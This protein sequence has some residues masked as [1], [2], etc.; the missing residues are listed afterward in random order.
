MKLV[1]DSNV[2]FSFFSKASTT[3]ELIFMLETFNLYTPSFCIEELIRYR[4][5]ICKKSG[6]SADGFEEA[7]EE[8]KLFVNVVSLSEYSEFLSGVGKISPD[9]DD[10]DLFALALKLDCPIWSNET[11]L[12]KQS[13]VK[14]LSTKEIIGLLF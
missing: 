14:V 3:R 12:K 10:V 5:V 11:V 1:V 6:L 2:L 13:V 4:D 8:L 9:P 7:L